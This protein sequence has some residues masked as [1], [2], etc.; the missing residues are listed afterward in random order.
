MEDVVVEL[1]LDE[2]DTVDVDA[3]SIVAVVPGSADVPNDPNDCAAAGAA[4]VSA[5]KAAI[6]SGLVVIILFTFV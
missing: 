3:L 1:E 6:V 2:F 4:A 5:T